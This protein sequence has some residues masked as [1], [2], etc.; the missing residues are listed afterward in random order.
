[1]M[2]KRSTATQHEHVLLKNAKPTSRY[3]FC[4]QLTR[5]VKCVISAHAM[6]CLE[7]VDIATNWMAGWGRGTL[8]LRIKFYV[9]II[10]VPT[11]SLLYKNGAIGNIFLLLNYFTSLMTILT[12]RVRKSVALEWRKEVAICLFTITYFWIYNDN[13]NPWFLIFMSYPWHRLS[14]AKGRKLWYILM[15]YL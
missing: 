12:L 2:F 6:Y 1:M 14:I 7:F 5:T 11:I 9:N 8:V 15:L 10:V 4:N 13:I 3:W